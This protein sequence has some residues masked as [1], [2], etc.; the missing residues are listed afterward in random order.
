MATVYSLLNGLKHMENHLL[1][2]SKL[3]IMED[4]LPI[5]PLLVTSNVQTIKIWLTT[6]ESLKASTEVTLL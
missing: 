2:M 1:M 6:M 4:L 3:L 5:T